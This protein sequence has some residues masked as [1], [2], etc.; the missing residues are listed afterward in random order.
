MMARRVLV[1][2]LSCVLVLSVG[3]VPSAAEPGE[4]GPAV[5]ASPV[6]VP[7]AFATDDAAEGPYVP[8]P[9]VRVL[10]TRNATQGELSARVGRRATVSQ[11]VAG[12]GGVPPTAKA[13][14]IN[15]T[16]VSPTAAGFVTVWPSGQTRPEVSSINFPAGAVV[17][18]F[19]IA[20]VGADGRVQI[21]NH[22]GTVHVVFDVVGYVPADASYTP[23]P[24]ARVLDTRNA[25]QGELSAPV[26]RRTTVSQ[27]VAGVG[28]VPATARAVA[29]NITAVTPTQAGFVT[30]WP[31]GQTR[32][33]VS[34]IN[35]PAGA[36]VGNFVLAEVGADGRVQIYNHNGEVDVVFD[37]V[38][39][40]PADASSSYTPLPPA[41][42][43]DTRNATQGDLSARVGRR[44]TV[45]QRVAGVG[46]VP[47][48]ASA[49][50]INITAVAPSA[51]G[52]VTV[53]PSGRQR[54]EVSSINFP[55]GAVVGN[56]VIAQ[57]GANGKVDLYNHNGDVHVVFDVVGYFPAATSRAQIGAG[58]GFTCALDVLGDPWCWG[59]GGALGDGASATRLAPVRV[60]GLVD[61]RALSVGAVSVCAI[62]RAQA[63]WCWGNNADGRLGDGTTTPRP[64]PVRVAGLPPV[65]SIDVQAAHTCAVDL[66]GMAWCWGGNADGQLGDGT[67]TPRPTPVQVTGIDDVVDIAVGNG[68]TCAV[69]GAGD[70]WCWGA[71]ANGQLGDGTVTAEATTRPQR[72]SDLPSARAL[73]A[74]DVHTCAIATSDGTQRCWGS[75]SFGVLGDGTTTRQPL[76]VQTIGLTGVAGTSSLSAHRCATDSDGTA[77]CWG[78]N[79]QGRL[80]D[81]TTTSRL[82]PTTVI[83]LDRVQQLAAGGQHTC[84]LDPAGAPWCWGRNAEGQL[85]D[86][87]T[88]TRS[89]PASVR[90]YP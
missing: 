38:G 69:D 82:V 28:D 37:V 36:V 79:G 62:D 57:V 21:Y 46:G 76:P 55:A 89:T 70:T 43:L 20:E 16:A 72:V 19:V 35:F 73:D 13:V 48:G 81:G 49:V 67:T 39:Y 22:N 6:A 60:S 29:I 85:G 86:G 34:S 25:T 42:V 66:E 63:A 18:N 74:G 47:V 26:G 78:L 56:F 83:G 12:V 14:A 27:R 84:A 41:R 61:L 1:P 90:P 64:R 87:T 53:W 50:A 2:L 88:V 59:V 11:R 32:P 30:V 23:L 4:A 17:G 65:T 54:P 80:G 77:W 40:V 9:P 52:F 5:S 8:L 33:E 10:D 75:N 31:S 7:E 24:P 68:H 45:S 44:A 15:I 51:A 58:G 71:N 3:L